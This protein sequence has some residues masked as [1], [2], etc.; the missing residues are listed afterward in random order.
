MES[1][2]KAPSGAFPLTNRPLNMT[3]PCDKKRRYAD[4]ASAMS[5]AD[6]RL[7]VKKDIYILYVYECQHC[8]GWHLTKSP[9][10]RKYR[11]LSKD[12]PSWFN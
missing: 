6:Q 12:A 5:A 2:I 3:S 10:E 11:V 7:F 8:N 1:V 4:Q 9:S